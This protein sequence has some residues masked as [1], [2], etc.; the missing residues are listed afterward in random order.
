M[1]DAVSIEMPNGRTAITEAVFQRERRHSGRVRFFRRALPG[2]AIFILVAL[3]ARTAI[4]SLTDVS[5]DLAGTTIEGGKLIMDNP[6]MSGFT[7]ANRPYELSASRAI[8]DI[9]RTDSVDLE[10]I[11]AR[12]PVGMK[13]WAQVDAA[14][15]TL[16]R[17]SG[18]L[19]ITSP[20][21]IETT[22]GMKAH[23]K[24]AELV[25]AN[26][27]IHAREQVRIETGSSQ[28]TA[29]S[30]TVSGGGAVMV[31]ENNVKMRIEPNR[32]AT[33]PSADGAADAKD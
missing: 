20:T 29:E 2:L 23:L 27:D 17:N 3:M 7:A 24:S 9:T 10:G 25:M 5:I 14:T 11:E 26:G 13:E 16:Y 18:R 19:A 21:V 31:F 1:T 30:L 15:G 8:Q 12:L 32:V 4:T 33:R 28:V 6:R 22:D